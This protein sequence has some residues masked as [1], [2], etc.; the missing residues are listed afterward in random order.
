MKKIMRGP[1]IRKSLDLKAADKYIDELSIKTP[2]PFQLARNLSG[3]NQQKV[4]LAKILATDCDIIFFDEPTR[5]IDVGA[6]QEIYALM[7]KLVDEQGKTIIMISSEMPELI[8]MSDRILVM[9]DG[10]IAGELQKEQ[11]SQEAIM[12]LAS[13]IMGGTSDEKK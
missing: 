10:S 11:F 5:G 3:G 4:V 7:R 1:F 12:N 8:G 6:K 2:G 13:G 9:H